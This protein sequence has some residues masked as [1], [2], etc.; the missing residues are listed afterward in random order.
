MERIRKVDLSKLSEEEQFS[1]GER[2][3][4]KMKK[5]ID[6]DIEVLSKKMDCKIKFSHSFEESKELFKKKKITKKN[7][8]YELRTAEQDIL[9]KL[10]KIS[11]IYG[12]KTCLTLFKE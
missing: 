9:E 5:I 7:K 2:I 8:E 6:G 10:N 12:L 4:E 11:S 3:G 1:L